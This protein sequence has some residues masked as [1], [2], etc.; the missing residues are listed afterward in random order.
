MQLVFSETCCVIMASANLQSPRVHAMV[1]GANRPDG[2]VKVL[3]VL[4]ERMHKSW[5]ATIHGDQKVE[6]QIACPKEY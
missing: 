2:C 6:A 1:C 3:V 4:A 5:M